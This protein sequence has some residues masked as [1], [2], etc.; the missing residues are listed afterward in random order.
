MTTQSFLPHVL[1]AGVATLGFYKILSLLYKEATT[2][3]RRLP[4]PKSASL[5]FGN[6]QQLFN[7]EY[8]G[9]FALYGPTFQYKGPLGFSRLCTVDTMAQNHI[10]MHNEIYQ[11]PL[12]ARRILARA[13]GP[14]LLVAEGNEHKKQRKILNPAFGPAQIRDLTEIFVDKSIQLRDIWVSKANREGGST[15]IESLSWLSRMTLDVI[16]LAGF[17]YKFHALDG[18]RP[19]ELN[20]A[21]SAIFHSGKRRPMVVVLKS[22]IPPL[23]WI[24]TSTDVVMENAQRVM[25]RIGRELLASSRAAV[26][27]Y[28]KEVDQGMKTRNILSQLVKANTS[29]NNPPESR[30]SDEDVLAQ[31]PTFLVA[32]HETSSTATAWALYALSVNPNVQTKLREELLASRIEMPTMDELNA[33]PYLDRVVREVLRVHSPVPFVTRVVTVDDVIPLSHPVT[34]TNGTIHHSI[35]PDRWLSPPPAS[36]TIPGVWSN[37]MTFLGGPRACIGYRFSLVEIKALLFVLVR[38][39]EFGLAVP[40][41]D[42]GKK[43]MVVQRPVLKSDPEAGHVLPLKITPIQPL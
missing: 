10:I 33:L 41:D 11:R 38:A 35:Q 2:P 3:I 40:A 22:M 1:A 14:G 43:T 15:R 16:G 29:P 9:W 21:F 17:N 31:I 39:F 24:R 27:P 13:A 18:D 7:G 8:E 20:Q 36:G 26:S 37:Q 23:N 5:L 28:Q 4:G 12:Q 32:G 30:L 34:D 42:I 25:A 19:N 6:V